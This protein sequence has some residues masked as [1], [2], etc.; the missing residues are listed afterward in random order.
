MYA[1]LP[2]ER[3]GV[4]VGP[5]GRAKR[6]I[7]R[8]TGVKLTLNSETG[9]V[10]IEPGDD[11]LGVLKA[12]DVIV[13]IARGFSAERAFR[14]LENDQLLEIIDIRDFAGGS[15]RAVV[16]LKGRLIGERGKTRRIIEQTTNAHVSVYGRT[17]AAIGS[18]EQLA[19]VRGAVQM[20][21]AGAKHSTVYKFLE[22]KRRE[23]KNRAMPR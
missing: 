4:A 12:R 2:K 6:E 23:M 15:D 18:V 3:I 14:L 10:Q 22:R 9:E 21:L 19:V 16:R 1:R 20:L 17:V 7:E 5:D 8:R 11:P 13:A